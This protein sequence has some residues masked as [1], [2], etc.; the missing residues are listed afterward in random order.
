MKVFARFRK[1]A[2]LLASIGSV[3]LGCIGGNVHAQAKNGTTLAAYKTIDVCSVNATT[4]RYSGSVSVWNEG[5][6]DTQG[7]TINDRIQTKIGT[8]WVDSL[9]VPITVTGQIAAGT[10]MATATVFPYSVEGPPLPDGVRNAAL[11]QI[12]NHSGSIGKA[13]GPEPKATFAG[14]V[15]PC[16][17]TGGCTYTQGYWGS[18]PGVVWPAGYDRNAAFYL[19]GQSWQQVMDTP[20]NVSQGYYQLAHQY[21]AAVLN[22]A[23]GALVPSGVQD[24]ITLAEAWLNANVPGA[25]TANGSCGTQKTW[26]AILAE[27]NEGS[28]PGGPAHCGD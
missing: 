1:T 9:S 13:K 21:I 23:N 25:C 3:A 24:T 20:V 11:I 4:W 10:T 6:V 17:T 2:L 19:S 15:L 26:A 16:P 28:Y 8:N 7:L 22:K 5:A 18:K 27:Y 12:T 14:T